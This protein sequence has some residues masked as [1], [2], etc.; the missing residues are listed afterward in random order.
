MAVQGRPPKPPTK[1]RKRTWVTSSQYGALALEIRDARN[2]AGLS[3]RELAARLGKP[4]SWVA[5]VEMKE[6]RLDILEFIALA[7]ALRLSEMDLLK[8]IS[9]RLSARIEI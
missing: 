9:K 8:I 7:R 4:P 6:R 3:Q 2:R 5:K 1:P